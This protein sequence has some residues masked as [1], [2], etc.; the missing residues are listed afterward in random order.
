MEWIEITQENCD[1]VYEAIEQG[2]PVMI[3]N[4]NNCLNR[5]IYGTIHDM[6]LGIGT[7]GKNKG[8]YYI[9]LP[10]LK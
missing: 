2:Y 10:K 3:A 7:M 8:Y 1:K 6:G 9:V 4:N 5:T